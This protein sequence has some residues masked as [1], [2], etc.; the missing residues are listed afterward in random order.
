LIAVV[1]PNGDV[2]PTLFLLFGLSYEHLLN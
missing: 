2:F 1:I